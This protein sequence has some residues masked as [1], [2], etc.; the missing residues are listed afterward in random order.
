MSPGRPPARRWPGPTDDGRR[1]REPAHLIV[2]ARRCLFGR[3]LRRARGTPPF[4]ERLNPSFIGSGQKTTLTA[5]TRACAGRRRGFGVNAA[6]GD[7]S[8][9]LVR[10]LLFVQRFLKQLSRLIVIELLRP[11]L[12]RAVHGHLVVFHSLSSGD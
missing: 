8:Q 11:C 9:L 5:R 7:L 6:F 2:T 10:L 1:S 3:A 4:A 12:Q